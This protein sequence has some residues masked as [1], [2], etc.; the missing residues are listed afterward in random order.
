[1]RGIDFKEPLTVE[2]LGVVEVRTLSYS[3]R[4][5]LFERIR[6]GDEESDA[7]Q[8]EFMLQL[9]AECVTY[10]DDGQP[11]GTAEEWDLFAGRHTNQALEV[12][13]KACDLNGFE[14]EV[15]EKN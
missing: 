2:H 9:L 4:R 10:Q 8:S 15:V 12:F 5:R 13:R 3:T 14:P 7:Y 11:C 1:M 6:E